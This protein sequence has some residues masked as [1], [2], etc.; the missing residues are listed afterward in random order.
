MQKDIPILY[1]FIYSQLRRKFNCSYVQT[2]YI[3]NEM[4]RRVSKIPKSLFYHIIHEMEYYKLL[5]RI[6]HK[7]IAILPNIQVKR[8]DQLNSTQ[9]W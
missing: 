1:L 2:S 3:F 7:A 6:N 8:L 5:Q 9:L 4:S